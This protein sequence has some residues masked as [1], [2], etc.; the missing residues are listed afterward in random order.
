M[1]PILWILGVFLASSKT[2]S[3]RQSSGA[4]KVNMEPSESPAKIPKFSPSL[5]SKHY[6]HTVLSIMDA[7][8][9]VK[10]LT[11]C[12]G[13]NHGY[14]SNCLALSTLKRNDESD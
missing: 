11:I 14:I 4:L 12:K 7:L 3:L 5:M 8:I 10:S 13:T 6:T 9:E 1:M 2:Q